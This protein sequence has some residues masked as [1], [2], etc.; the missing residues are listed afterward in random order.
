MGAVFNFLALILVFIFLWQVEIDPID[1]DLLIN[2]Q[3]QYLT[4][5]YSSKFRKII[6]LDKFKE[7]FLLKEV[8]DYKENIQ[9]FK[10]DFHEKTA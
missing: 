7:E 8:N 2:E 1:N 4:S 5:S 10:I 9:K 6:K 3:S